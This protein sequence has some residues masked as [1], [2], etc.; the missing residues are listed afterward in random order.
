MDDNDFSKSSLIFTNI[1]NTQKYELCELNHCCPQVSFQLRF[2]CDDVDGGFTVIGNSSII[3]SGFIAH[4]SL[5][6]TLPISSLDT[7]TIFRLIPKVDEFT[8]PDKKKVT[9]TEKIK[10]DESVDRKKLELNEAKQHEVNSSKPT[11]TLS[12]EN[13]SIEICGDQE[14]RKLTFFPTFSILKA[15]DNS[16]FHETRSTVRTCNIT[17]QFPRAADAESDEDEPI[18][19]DSDSESDEDI[20]R[21]LEKERERQRK[22]AL[23]RREEKAKEE[24]L[25]K[26]IAANPVSIVLR[27]R[28][29][30]I[31]GDTVKVAIQWYICNFDKPNG[32]NTSIPV[33]DVL[34]RN[35]KP[36]SASQQQGKKKAE[37]SSSSNATKTTSSKTTS[38]KSTVSHSFCGLAISSMPRAP[39]SN[40]PV[41][42]PVTMLSFIV[43][44]GTAAM[45]LDESVL[46]M[47]IGSVKEIIP[48]RQ[49]CSEGE[50]KNP[51]RIPS[52]LQARC[53]IQLIQFLR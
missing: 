27:S 12:P 44:T 11:S 36:V 4:A 22:E 1:S 42:S 17:V 21:E 19:E 30:V 23:K 10:K 26:L 2:G 48:P 50:G 52:T 9:G 37:S 13:F 45:Y 5:A 18:D 28:R 46:G 31:P 6:R 53:R 20:K 33:K 35:I 32:K 25:Q 49:L 16:K 51:F 7:T 8:E 47:R 40:V 34:A 15:L 3:L 38:S 41:A 24:E 43:Q 39:A 14:A 29:K